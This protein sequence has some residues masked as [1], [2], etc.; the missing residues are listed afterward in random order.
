MVH[1]ALD[2]KKK[3]MPK[4]WTQPHYPNRPKKCMYIYMDKKEKPPQQ[5]SINSIEIVIVI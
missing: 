3:K 5:N 4:M 1:N 2:L